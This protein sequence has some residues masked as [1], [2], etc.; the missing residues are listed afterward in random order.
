MQSISDPVRSVLRTAAGVSTTIGLVAFAIAVVLILIL[1]QRRGKTPPIL[2]GALIIVG[3]LALT[4]LLAETLLAWAG[5]H[6]LY[7][8]R[9]TVLGSDGLPTRPDSIWSNLGGEPQGV[10]G[11]WLFVIP[12]AAMPQSGKIV[13]YASSAAICEKGLAAE[14]LAGDPNPQVTLQL[15]RDTS[16]LILGIVRDDQN[17]T[18]AGAQVFVEGRGD[19]EVV[20]TNSV[21]A[22]R[23]PAYA[24]RCEQ[25]RVSAQAA[26]YEPSTEYVY[27]GTS[28]SVLT[29]VRSAR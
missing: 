28:A 25:V 18:V 29:L 12:R 23:L 2:W 8:L 13:V 3:L 26:G 14:T 15:V 6:S 4:P 17:R 19:R 24:T 7:R 27:P 22:F 9:V 1:W 11:G 21:G 10:A 16:E 5:Q 20:T